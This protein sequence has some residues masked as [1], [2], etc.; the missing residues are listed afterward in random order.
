[1]TSVLLVFMMLLSFFPRQNAAAKSAWR[2]ATAEELQTV[3]P[4]RAH[5][6]NERIETE[7]RTASGIVNQRGQMIAGVVLI[8]AGYSA[9]G[10]YSHY[11]LVQSPMTIGDVNLQ[12]GAYVLGWKRV[13]AGLDVH[14]YEALTGAE[15]GSSIAREMPS[16]GRVETIR[17]WPPGEHSIIQIGR[18][19]LSYKL[20]ENS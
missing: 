13:E 18:F 19:E 4:T 17:I 5:V 3:L 8:T 16:P 7:T 1:M 11:L 15:Q 12:P 6:G 10:K 20:R 9:D 2:T 14:I